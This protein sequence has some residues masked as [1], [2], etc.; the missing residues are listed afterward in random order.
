[1]LLSQTDFS[2]AETQSSIV[3]CYI[4]RFS[5]KSK[6]I[7]VFVLTEEVSIGVAVLFGH[8]SFLPSLINTSIQRVKVAT[9]SVLELV[10][11][12][13]AMEMW[14]PPITA[15]LVIILA[16]M[17]THKD[18]FSIPLTSEKKP[19]QTS[20]AHIMSNFVSVPLCLFYCLY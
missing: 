18:L 17:Y 12:Y 5:L 11:L 15:L 4:N 2:L 14:K 6:Q 1:M 20:Y 16:Y 7:I 19:Q 9:I 10:R 8:I 3:A 13:L